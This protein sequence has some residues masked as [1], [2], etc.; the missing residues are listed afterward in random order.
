MLGDD[1]ITSQGDCEQDKGALE[2]VA[3]YDT[4]LELK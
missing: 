4:S 3:W 1:E 2:Q